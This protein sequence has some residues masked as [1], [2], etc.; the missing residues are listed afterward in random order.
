MT[1]SDVCDL[2]SYFTSPIL[3]TM[4]FEVSSD[5]QRPASNDY[6]DDDD[7][8][9]EDG[10]GVVVVVP[11]RHADTTYSTV[12]PRGSSSN[13]LTGTVSTDTS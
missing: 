12:P 6:D 9:D 13:N 5:H 1:F 8:D 2:A 4:G 10:V 3:A 7:D 11:S